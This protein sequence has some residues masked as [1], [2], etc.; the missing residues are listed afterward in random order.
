MEFLNECLEYLWTS[1][2]DPAPAIAGLAGR[3]SAEGASFEA[4]QAY[5]FLAEHGFRMKDYDA[6][7][8]QFLRF[9][10]QVKTDDPDDAELLALAYRKAGEAGAHSSRAYKDPSFAERCLLRAYAICRDHL[11]ALA[12]ELVLL[13]EILSFHY[14]AAAAE[15]DSR[16]MER[17]IELDLEAI[18]LLDEY[19]PNDADWKSVFFR[20]LGYLH[21]ER[22]EYERSKA[23]YCAAL[24]LEFQD[25]VPEYQ[26]RFRS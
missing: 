3:L 12:E 10:D 6:A 21:E 8:E 22:G 23:C 17:A 9:L 5:L 2:E 26:G 13:C 24:N 16:E 7:L 14:F 20:R 4:G 18:A 25:H 1:C 15:Y 19:F 11:P